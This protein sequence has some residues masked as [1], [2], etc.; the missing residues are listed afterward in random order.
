MHS[1]KDMNFYII[2]PFEKS[3]KTP[4]GSKLLTWTWK[5]QLRWN[6]KGCLGEI[7]RFL[8]SPRSSSGDRNWASY[9]FPKLGKFGKFQEICIGKIWIFKTMAQILEL[10]PYF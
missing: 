3:T 5:T 1:S 6:Q 9:G 2:G 4:F 8:K 7:L 10:Q